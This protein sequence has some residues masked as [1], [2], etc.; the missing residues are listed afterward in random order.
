MILKYF[1]NVFEQMVDDTVSKFKDIGIVAKVGDPAANEI[2]D[3]DAIKAMGIVGIYFEVEDDDT[4]S[5]TQIHFDAIN[6]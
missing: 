3:V 2:D 6:P 1:T 5:V 4:R